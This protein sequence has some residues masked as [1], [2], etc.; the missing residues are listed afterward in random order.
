MEAS[1]E[2]KKGFTLGNFYHESLN[3]GRANR[4][5]PEVGTAIKRGGWS[6][7]KKKKEKKKGRLGNPKRRGGKSRAMGV[8]K[9]EEQ[10]TFRGA[11]DKGGS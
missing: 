4:R 10:R 11:A 7:K 6:C 5:D 9:S 8:Q 3:P 1:Q 2:R